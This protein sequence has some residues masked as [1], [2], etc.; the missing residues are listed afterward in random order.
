M[1]ASLLLASGRVFAEDAEGAVRVLQAGS[2][3]SPGEVVIT[4]AASA[5]L[6]HIDGA[7]EV[8]LG[9]SE[10]WDPALGAPAGEAFTP[11]DESAPLQ[12]GEL[13]SGLIHRADPGPMNLAEVFSAATPVHAT[14]TQESSVNSIDAMSE[15][16]LLSEL[17]GLLR[18]L[19][20][21]TGGDAPEAVILQEQV[22]TIEEAMATLPSGNL[23][24]EEWVAELF[25]LLERASDLAYREYG[26]HAADETSRFALGN[27]GLQAEALLPGL[28]SVEPEPEEAGVV[29]DPADVLVAD[30]IL[31][32]LTVQP[33]GDL[34]HVESIAGATRMTVR[35]GGDEE[36]SSLWLNLPL[37]AMESLLGFDAPEFALPD[38]A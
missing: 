20:L 29:A 5:A 23:P 35:E 22:A 31:E 16:A 17:S 9:A 8:S 6:F 19:Q 25:D 32:D 11:V 7:G 26:R 30:S 18:A 14:F 37:G 12:A 4:G 33:L 2:E 1:T 13:A 28:L 38:T 36:G 34:L 3:L 21:V 24:G 15:T 27:A 10:R